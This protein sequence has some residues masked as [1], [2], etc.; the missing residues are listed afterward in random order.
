MVNPRIG[1]K[2]LNL[3]KAALRKAF[4]RSDVYKSMMAAILVPMESVPA[5]IRTK[6]PRVE[7]W[8]ICP[9]CGQYE[10]KSYFELD[11]T[12][13]I[14]PVHTTFAE[15][16]LD[17]QSIAD[18][19]FCDP[20][21]LKPLCFKCH[22]AKTAAENAERDKFKAAKREQVK[23]AKRAAKL[24][25]KAVDASHQISQAEKTKTRRVKR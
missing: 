21:N 2:E 4:V 5:E 17:V 18:A 15:H 1:K 10:A 19:I 12:V 8:A 16:Y 24:A 6:R 23:A 13:P 22:E 7:N 25:A 11:H 3:I 9:G 14:V 20:S